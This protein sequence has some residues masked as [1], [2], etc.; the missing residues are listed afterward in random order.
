MAT[1]YRPSVANFLPIH[2][3]VID[4]GGRPLTSGKESSLPNVYFCGFSV[5]PAGMLYE[6]GL[7][8]KKIARSISEKS[9]SDFVKNDHSL[10]S[11]NTKKS[12]RKFGPLEQQHFTP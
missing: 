5:S 11:L 10:F 2:N 6:I 4:K 3:N 9:Y 12:P 7:E 8:A 1:G